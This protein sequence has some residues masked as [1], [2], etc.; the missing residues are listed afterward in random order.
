[1]TQLNIFALFITILM[2][3]LFVYYR[4][5]YRTPEIQELELTQFVPMAAWLRAGI[6]F[7][8]LYLISWA[9]GVKEAILTNPI[10]TEEQLADPIWWAWVV[11][12]FAFI[13]FAYWGIWARYTIRFDRKLD[14]IPQI[15]YG[16]LWGSAFGQLFLSLWHISKII[17]PN[18]ATWQTWLLTYVLITI[19]QWFLMDMYWDVYISPEH[20]SPKSIKLK[21]P[22]T[23]IP[24]MTLCLTFFA[25]YENY[26]I[27][28]VLQTLALTGASIFMRMPAPWSKEKTPSANREPS[29]FG[30][31]PRC[32]GY[33]PD[34]P[35]KDP[36]L[37][38]A[39]L[40]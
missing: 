14:L 7:C 17:G 9:T 13:L 33:T 16:L 20:D 21:V 2:C 24:N 23:H 38:A 19:C 6:L 26:A 1:M 28:I 36:Y 39:H 37:K 15:V 29:K 12:L 32:K 31:L 27:F 35:E 8:L 22:L 30:G 4:R 10:A 34:D 40:V 11:G 3:I 5:N 18:W 25:L